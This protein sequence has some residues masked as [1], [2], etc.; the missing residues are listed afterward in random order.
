MAPHRDDEVLGVGGTLARAATEGEATYVV[1]VTQGGPP[2]FDL[3]LVARLADEAKRAH[4]LLGVRE[5]FELG[6]PAAAIDGVA[7]QDL[8]AELTRVV[9]EVRPERLF[10]PYGGDLH[11][12]HQLIW[13][14]SLVAARPSTDWTPRAVYAYETLSE[15]NWNAPYFSPAFQPTA[16]IDISPHLDAKVKAMEIYASQIRPFPHERSAEAIRALAAVRGS[17]IGVEAAE[18]F[19]LIRQLL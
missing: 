19:V 10:I 17:A 5:T 14:S 7:H 4:A 11:M 13:L 16:Y 15:T 9:R 1:F 2:T 3:E 12:D 6:F 8:N 18:A